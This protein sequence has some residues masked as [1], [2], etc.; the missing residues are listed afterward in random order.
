M[1]NYSKITKESLKKDLDETIKISK[2]LVSEIKQ[3]EDANLDSFDLFER[4]NPLSGLSFWQ[5][6]IKNKV[7]YFW[8]SPTMLNMII[9]LKTFLQK[10]LLSDNI[11]FNMFLAIAEDHTNDDIEKSV[12]V[13]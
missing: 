3:S 6:A 9:K 2:N 4:F 5:K 12:L 8:A 13:T 7:N 10:E 1:F 11:L